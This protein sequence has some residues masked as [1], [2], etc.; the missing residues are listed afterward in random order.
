MSETVAPVTGVQTVHAEA[1]QLHR[2]ALGLVDVLFQAIT[3]MGPSVSVVFLF[4]LIAL[5]AGAAM[6]IS[7]ALAVLVELVIANTVAEFSRYIPSSGGYFTFVAETRTALGIPHRVELLAYDPLTPPA[8]LGFLG[9]LMADIL[10]TNTGIDIPWWLFQG[11]HPPGLGPYL[12]G[13]THQHAY[14][15]DHGIA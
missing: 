4:P 14:R 8:V 11:V 10:Q 12:P 1:T 7:L 2:G 15:S 6:P 3:H 5:N 13:H 9:F